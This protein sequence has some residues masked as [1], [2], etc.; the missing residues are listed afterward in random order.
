MTQEELAEAAG[1]GRS[2][3]QNFEMG[4][5]FTRTPPSLRA[6]TKA[7]GWSYDRAAS[8]V[9]GRPEV[10]DAAPQAA[11]GGVPEDELTEVVTS[12]MV[13]VVD[14]MTASEIRDVSRRVAEELKRRA[15]V[16]GVPVRWRT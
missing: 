7:L 1:V 16:R 6:I 4:R 14:T 9:E 10:D 12:A 8:I 11:A 2:S 3:V 15:S 13:A 5:P